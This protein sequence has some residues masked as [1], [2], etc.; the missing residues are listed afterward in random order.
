MERTLQWIDDARESDSLKAFQKLSEL[1]RS[2]FFMSLKEKV[3][4]S[5]SNRSNVL[6]LLSNPAKPI[7]NPP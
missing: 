2:L 1:L 6:T 5:I 3:F 7:F 4:K